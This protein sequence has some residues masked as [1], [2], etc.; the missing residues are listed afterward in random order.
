MAKRS[1]IRRSASEERYF[2]QKVNEVDENDGKND[3]NKCLIKDYYWKKV[4]L[5][6]NHLD[7]HLNKVH[8]AEASEIFAKLRIG[9]GPVGKKPENSFKMIKQ[10][11]MIKKEEWVIR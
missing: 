7:G 4:S 5:D 1:V 2:Y 8:Y 6:S 3:L 10:Q 11:C 9:A